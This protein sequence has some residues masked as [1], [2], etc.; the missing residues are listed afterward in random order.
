MQFRGLSLPKKRK[1]PPLRMRTNPFVFCSLLC[2]LF[3]G[4]VCAQQRH[5]TGRLRDVNSREPLP[6]MSVGVEGYHS[7]RAFTDAEGRFAL[8]A[9]GDSLVLVCSGPG[10]LTRTFPLGPILRDTLNLGDLF[11]QPEPAREEDWEAGAQ[12][13]QVSDGEGEPDPGMPL[14]QAGRDLFLSRAA[15]DFSAGFFRIRGLDSRETAVFLNGVPMNRAY[16]GRP[17]WSSWAGLTDI[18]RHTEPSFG[19]AFSN[20]AFSGLLGSAAIRAA[21]SALRPGARLTASFGN[22]SYQLRQ[23]A[24][25]N[26][27]VGPRG[28]GLLLSFANRVGTTGYIPGTPFSSQAGYAALEWRPDRANSLV[29]AGV[30]SRTRRGLSAPLTEEVAGLMGSRYNPYWGWHKGRVRSARERFEA[31]PLLLLL[32]T[33]QKP[34]LTWTIAAGAQWGVQLRTRLAS[35]GA[36]NPDP[37]YY[38]NLPS[39]YYNSPLGANYYNTTLSAN[40]F[41]AAPQ[42]DW[43][44][45]YGTNLNPGRAGKAAYLQFGDE[46]RGRRMNLR[47]TFSYRFPMRLSVQAA[48]GYSAED[49]GFGGRLLDL[50]G[51]DYHEDRDPFNGTSNDL[52]GPAQKQTGDRIGYHYSLSARAWDGF[53][54]ARWQQGRWEAGGS[55][56]YGSSRYGREGFFRNQRYPDPAAAAPRML[57]FDQLGVK[58][59]LGY[60]LSGHQWLY[61]HWG[62]LTRPPLLRDAFADARENSTPFP[63]DGPESATGGSMDLF[64][65]YPW[66][67][68]RLTGYYV[69]MAGGRSLRSYFAETGYGEAF[70]R[71]ATG[72]IASLHRGVEAGL[73]FRVN[74][75]LSLTLSAAA[76]A[77][78]YSGDPRTWLYYFPDDRGLQSLPG[79]GVLDLGAPRLDGYHLGRGPE[80]AWSVG[81]S[82]RDP[83]FWWLDLRANYL[84][85]SYEDLAVLRHARGFDLL[86]GTG[87]PDP[88]ARPGALEAYRAQR[89]LPASYLLNLSMGKS[90]LKGRHYISVFAGFNNL[91]DQISR[92]G[93]YQQGRLATL[94]GLEE[95]TRSGHPS[96]GPRYW[97]GPGRTYFLNISWSF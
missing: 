70:M 10:Y 89:P 65:R 55:V 83:R 1:Q 29:L 84:G 80:V 87:E 61:V 43:E 3:T 35:F 32:Y 59:G 31:E 50:L 52:D 95:D 78:T 2:T 28:L 93:G 16:D 90:W 8:A 92:T 76:G 20:T 24:T 15:F 54:Q 82:Y 17:S 58:A 53:L 5:V 22:R 30:L 85:N 81:L 62:H 71:E 14:L 97:Y 94:S 96:F 77:Y 91:F 13:L 38:R 75:S 12:G 46:Q 11:M 39:F 88:A 37:S 19:W 9:S 33:R 79:N 4:A 49:L 66:L 27:G 7:N 45:L 51:A 21:P 26:T 56:R 18:G 6:G 40:S 68:G 41:R 74:P 60:R 36:P 72:G 57:S 64:F 44:A 86:P 42:I 73:D 34:G 47:T 69:R 67:K 25:Y 63:L 48:L 23:M